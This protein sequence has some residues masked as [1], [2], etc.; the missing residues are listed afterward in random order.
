[1]SRVFLQRGGRAHHESG[2][3]VAIGRIVGVDSSFPLSC[4][5]AKRLIRGLANLHDNAE[6]VTVGAHGGVVGLSVGR[7]FEFGF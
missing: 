6:G 3:G 7:H 4:R 5:A 1:M 2:D